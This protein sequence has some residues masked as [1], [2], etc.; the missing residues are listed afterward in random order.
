LRVG[1]EDESMTKRN[2]TRKRKRA[3]V[4][5]PIR[6][7]LPL[8]ERIR[9]RHWG[10]HESLKEIAKALRI[11]IGKVERAVKPKKPSKPKKGRREVRGAGGGGQ[12]KKRAT[13][14]TWTERE[15]RLFEREVRVREREVEVAKREAR[16]TRKKR[17]RVVTEE[18]LL[19]RLA[20]ITEQ[21]L[22]DKFAAQYASALGISIREVYTLA[23]SPEVA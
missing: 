4:R 9:I 6:Q 21:G 1:T 10:R 2:P 11:P 22:L 14:R 23:L 15:D 3:Q 8:T 16:L 20:R 12:K 18:G 7:A 5:K 19:R 13:R 17:R